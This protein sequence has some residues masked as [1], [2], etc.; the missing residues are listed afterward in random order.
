MRKAMPLMKL[1]SKRKEKNVM[2]SD[3]RTKAK[4]KKRKLEQNEQKQ[5]KTMFRQED[6]TKTK[7]NKMNKTKSQLSTN[8]PPLK[9][10]AKRK[11]KTNQRKTYQW[12]QKYLVHAN[13]TPS[14]Y[15]NH[16]KCRKIDQNL[17]YMLHS[18]L[19]R[20]GLV[21]RWWHVD[22]PAQGHQRGWEHGMMGRVQNGVM[23]HFRWHDQRNQHPNS[24]YI[25]PFTPHK[26]N[27]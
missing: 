26:Q 23:S 6:N 21:P 24:N 3:H 4:N 12:R 20:V 11:H 9:Q 22:I 1:K 25:P 2:M 10:W 15:N 8:S 5:N 13:S 7:W 14:T 18:R 17:T 16:D 19:C 27:V